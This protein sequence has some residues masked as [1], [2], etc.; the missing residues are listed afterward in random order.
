MGMVV[1]WDGRV[2]EHVVQCLVDTGQPALES[3][4]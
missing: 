2:A 1:G 4:G 3:V